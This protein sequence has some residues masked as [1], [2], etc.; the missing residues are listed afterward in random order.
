MPAAND[1][2]RSAQGHSGDGGVAASEHGVVP[3]ASGAARS[4]QGHSADGGAAASEQGVMIAARIGLKLCWCM[5]GFPRFVEL[6]RLL[7]LHN[8]HC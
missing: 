2:A 6:H 1:A 4:A 5:C 7:L 8:R 3:A